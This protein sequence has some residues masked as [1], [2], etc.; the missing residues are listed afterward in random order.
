M[1]DQPS[2]R[3]ALC[4]P[5]PNLA[6]ACSIVRDDRLHLRAERIS[7]LRAAPN[8]IVEIRSP[9]T[10]RPTCAKVSL[11]LELIGPT[12]AAARLDCEELLRAL[13][14]RAAISAFKISFIGNL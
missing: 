9:T 13:A 6:Q 1:A 14:T 11:Y 5:A 12:L 3:S 7:Y 2:S 4:V 10:Q 8:L